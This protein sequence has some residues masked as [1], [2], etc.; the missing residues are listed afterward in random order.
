M[1]GVLGGLPV[2]EKF[3]KL[4]EAM[5]SLPALRR[6]DLDL[7]AVLSVDVSPSGVGAVISQLRG[8]GLYSLGQF[9]STFN[10]GK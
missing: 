6:F 5:S 8:H 7:Q 2:L 10:C 3:I 4:K 1:A 9:T